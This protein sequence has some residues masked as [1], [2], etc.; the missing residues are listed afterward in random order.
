[1]T[2]D[3]SLVRNRRLLVALLVVA[4]TLNFIDRQIAG[5]LAEPIKHDLN[6]SDKQLGW[7]GGTAFALFYTVLAIPI[8]RFADRSDRSIGLTIG[9]ALWSLAT[10]VFANAHNYAQRFLSTMSLG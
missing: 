8:A 6:L 7:L 1:M 10:G 9:L 4:Y 5:I 2:A 3:A